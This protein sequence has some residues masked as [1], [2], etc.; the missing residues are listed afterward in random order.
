MEAQKLEEIITR[1]VQ[2][3]MPATCRYQQYMADSELTPS[4]H[5]EDHQNFHTLFGFIG[6]AGN[7]FLMILIGAITTFL[8]AA[9]GW[10][11]IEIFSKKLNQ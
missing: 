3:A 8:V 10:G 7:R 1:A 2:N 6:K 5:I 4:R 11:I 9:F